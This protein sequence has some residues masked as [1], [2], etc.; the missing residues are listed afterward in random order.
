M[1]SWFCDEI[2][3]QQDLRPI[4]LSWMAIRFGSTPVLRMLWGLVRKWS[5]GST[6]SLA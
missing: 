2:F 1:A 5:L 3:C 6:V 4:R